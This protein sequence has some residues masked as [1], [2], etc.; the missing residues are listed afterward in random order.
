MG[1]P[2]HVGI[3]LP[4]RGIVMR[5]EGPPDVERVLALAEQA[6]EAGCDSVWVGDSLLSKPRLE[7]LTTLSAV[8][9]RTKKVQ[10]GTA[11]LLAAMRQ[12]VL[13]AHA[14]ATV[15]LISRGRLILAMG[16]GGAFNEALR[17]EWDAAGVPPA[18]RAGRL[19]EM[20]QILRRLWT[21]DDVSFEGRYFQLTGVTAEPKPFQRTGVPLLLACHQRAGI[22]AQFR[23]AARWGDGFISIGDTPQ[24]YAQAVQ[25]M[26]TLAREEGRDP[27]SLGAALYMTVNLNSDEGKAQEEANA[28]L[29]DY[30]GAN[31]WGDRWAPFGP[32]EAVLQR[33]QEYAASGVNHFIIRFAS[34]DAPGQLRAFVQQVLPALR[35]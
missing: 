3:L 22:E 30:Y 27:E 20:L 34:Y 23:R 7:P 31:I 9:A 28:Y 21:E 29:M 13:L 6:E 1:N 26:A 32:P 35:G 14:A 8:A 18:Q 33:L 24:E 4:T 2:F 17:Q 19:E 25:H 12:P 5:R 10:L 15:D 11:V 16:A